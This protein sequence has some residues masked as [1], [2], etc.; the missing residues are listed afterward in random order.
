MIINN[1]NNISKSKTKLHLPSIASESVMLGVL[2]AIVGGF[3]DAYTFIGKGGVFANAQTGNIVLVG[4][5][6]FNRNWSETL[7]HI[8]PVFAFIVGVIVSEIVRKNSITFFTSK[9]EHSVLIFEIL[10]LLII[11]FLPDNTP[12]N[13]ITVSI[14][15]VASLQYCSFKKL[16][17]QPFATTM[18][19]GNLR[20]ASQAA[21]TA[22][23]EKDRE[24]AIKSIRYFSVILSFLLGAFLGGLLTFYIGNQAVWAV[25]ILLILTFILLEINESVTSSSS[26]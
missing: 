5:D 26:K 2:L 20:S 1:I 17:D 14:S 25:D 23:T 21:Y 10:I 8:L 18:C 6:I 16:V 19:T 13:V 22:F 24:S 12:N 4:I 7:V 15:F 11:G 3:L 9:W